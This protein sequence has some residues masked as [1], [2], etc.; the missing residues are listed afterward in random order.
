LAKGEYNRVFGWFRVGLVYAVLL[1]LVIRSRPTPLSVSIGFFI[2]ALGEVLRIWAAGH[3][4]KT[5]ELVTSGPYRYTRNPLYLGRLLIFSGLAIAAVLPYH[6]QWAVLG[7]GWLV[8]FGY[9]L[10]RKEQVEPARL[11]EVHG[12]AYERYHEAVPALFPKLMPYSASTARGWSSHRAT[13]NRE[14][15]MAIG[16]LVLNLYLLWRSYHP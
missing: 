7:L 5:A 12:E 15:W 3:L 16:L 9:Y 2:M 8:F 1:A 4:V 14:H 10:R 11:R 13:L 6:L